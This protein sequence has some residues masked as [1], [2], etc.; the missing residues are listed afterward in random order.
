MRRS[1]VKLVIWTSLALLTVGMTAPTTPSFVKVDTPRYS[2]EV[3]RGWNV[4]DETPWGARDILPEEGA[5]KL[6]AMTAGPS[7]ASW[8]DLYRTSLY[9][10]LREEPGQPTP[11]RLGETK[12]GYESMSFEVH[13]A[14]DF[15]NRRYTLVKDDR[16]YA[17]ALS[18]RIP[19]AQEEERYRLLFQHMVDTAILK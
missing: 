11:F 19:S 9:F 2:F 7:Q 6:G 17:L 16:G 12:Q 3:P 10:I 18:V 5:G 4:G 15:A 8:E 14:D 1:V 13:N